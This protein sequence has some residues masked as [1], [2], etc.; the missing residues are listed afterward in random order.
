MLISEVTRVDYPTLDLIIT[1]FLKFKNFEPKD[2]LISV[3]APFCPLTKL[4]LF[5]GA[6][7]SLLNELCLVDGDEWAN[8]LI[9]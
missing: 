5:E 3:F 4:V 8:T 9:S 6:F 1:E 7:E 2:Q